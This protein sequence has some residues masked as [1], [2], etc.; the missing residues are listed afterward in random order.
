MVNRGYRYVLAKS[1]GTSSSCCLLL[2]PET[3]LLEED[4]QVEESNNNQSNNLTSIKN[5]RKNNQALQLHGKEYKGLQRAGGTVI[6][7]EKSKR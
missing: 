6:E 1:P 4:W 7:T 5:K 3:G 2:N